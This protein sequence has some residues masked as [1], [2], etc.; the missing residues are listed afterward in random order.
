[1]DKKLNIGHTAHEW[2]LVHGGAILED[3]KMLEDYPSLCNGSTIFLQSTLQGGAEANPDVDPD[4]P[5]SDEPC[6]VTHESFEE[7]GTVVL[8]MPCGHPISPGALMDYCWSE[9][10]ANKTEVRCFLCTKKWEI[11]SIKQYSGASQEEFREIEKRLSLNY[12][13]ASDDINQCPKCKSYC[14]RIHPDKACVVC[15]ICSKST[16]STYQFCWF[17]LRQ[18]NNRGSDSCGHEDCRGRE[19]LK[20]LQNTAKVIV[21]REPRVEIY[22]L[23][24]CPCCGEI[25]ECRDRRKYRAQCAKC[26]TEFCFICLRPKSQGSWFCDSS[27]ANCKLA[28]IQKKIPKKQMQ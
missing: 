17:C 19:D 24:A 15:K 25:M 7:H 1:M 22:A 10:N 21:Q 3:D 4:L 18:W 5:R 11:D 12:C 2:Y 9:L 16:G 13:S 20:R 8:M 6:M 14:S 23:R 28:P 27:R 26:Q